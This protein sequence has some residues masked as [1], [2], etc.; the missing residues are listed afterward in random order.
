MAGGHR[1]KDLI[2][3]LRERDWNEFRKERYKRVSEEGENLGEEKVL[4]G[5]QRKREDTVGV[6]N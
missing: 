1:I 4:N 2:R 6:S 3:K 5:G